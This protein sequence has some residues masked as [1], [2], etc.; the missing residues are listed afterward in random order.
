MEGVK[1]EAAER[2]D[3]GKTVKDN[4]A[5]HQTTFG[6]KTIMA[7]IRRTTELPADEQQSFASSH[8][9]GVSAR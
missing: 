5:K 6:Q 2:Y 8:K 7:S 1:Y 9:D 4:L 3:Q